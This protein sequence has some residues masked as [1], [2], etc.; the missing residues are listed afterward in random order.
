MTL[1]EHLLNSAIEE[2]NYFG[3]QEITGYQKNADGSFKLSAKGNLIPIFKMSGHREEES[4]YYLRVGEYWTELNESYNGRNDVAWSAAFISFLM[5]NSKLQKS[6]F[7]F[8]S[9]HSKYI[10]KA[11]LSKQNNDVSYGFWGYKLDEYS[12][13][14]GDLVCY[15]RGT[16]I[17]K[18]NYD[19]SSDDYESHSDL[20]VE[21]NGNTL[22]VIGGNVEDSVTM[23]HLELDNNGFLVDK[24]KK[25]FVILKNRLKNSEISI[26][27]TIELEIK[28]YAVTGDGVRLRSYPIK[29][30]Q[31]VI[32]TLF[33]GF[34]VDFLQTSNDNQWSKVKYQDKIGWMSNLYLKPISTERFDNN[35]ENILEIVSKSAI[36]NYN[37]KDRGKAPL[38]YYQGMALMFARLYCRLKNGDEIVEEISKPATGN[39]KKDS[40]SYYEDIFESFGMDNE[41]SGVDTLR[42][43]FVLLTGLG[44]R[45]SSGRHCVGRDTTADNTTAETAEAGLFQTSYNVRSVSLLLPI[46]FENYKTKPDGFIEIFTKG[47]KPCGNNNWGNFGEGNGKEFQQL[48][49]ECPGFAVEF[50]AVAMRNTSNH[51]GPIINR[52]VEIKTECDIMF[53]KVQNY[54]DQN[55]IQRI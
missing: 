44:L 1:K 9:Q 25:W 52:K 24:S 28:K 13:E 42:H 4:P 48:S 53:L 29:E 8:N 30:E 45:E 5:K 18:I 3:K 11:I 49:K 47:V 37:W 12:P 27:D 10:R 46:V 41:S 34:E 26:N 50:T 20:V 19:S 15:V 32:A 55:N 54:L 40:L 36:I 14:V 43:C 6:D 21:K 23:K 7:L 22:R 51:W 31:N 35:I 17:G 16:A 33:K 39:P 2:W 38:G